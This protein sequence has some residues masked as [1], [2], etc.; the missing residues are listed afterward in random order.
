M[1]DLV[2]NVM[3]FKSTESTAKIIYIK[4]NDED[5]SK[6]VMQRDNIGRQNCWAPIEKILSL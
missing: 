6:M 1:N 5:A 3:G 4:F 2:V